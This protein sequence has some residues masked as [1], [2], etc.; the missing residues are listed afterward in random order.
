MSLK[1]VNMKLLLEMLL[2]KAIEVEWSNVNI[3]N[4]WLSFSILEM[5][6]LDGLNLN[7]KWQNSY[8][9]PMNATS[10]VELLGWHA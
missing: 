9:L 5:S 6:E 10:I 4:I 1:N 2:S 8:L 3:L 7:W